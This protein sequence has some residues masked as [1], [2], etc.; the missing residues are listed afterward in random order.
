MAKFVLV[1]G[2]WHGAWCWYKVVSRLQAAGHEA[3]AVDLPGMG[4]DVTPLS[5][6]TLDLWNDALVAVL[7][8]QSEPVVL[9]GHSR[10][11]LN[12][13]LAAATA[14]ERIKRLVYLCAFVPESGRSLFEQAGENTGSELS[15]ALV[16]SADGLS[17]VVA[18]SRL[19][20]IFYADCSEDDLTLARLSLKPEPLAP[21]NTPFEGSAENLAGI[22]KVYVECL[23][24]QAITIE[25]Q[26]RMAS[27]CD[28]V[29]T[30]DT[31]H[32]PFFS[33]PDALV[34]VLVGSAGN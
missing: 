9:V 30:M 5:E 24:D 8:D 26:R 11:G 14:P 20:D 15:T 31:S 3:V 22:D 4:A 12:I 21:L 7:R 33:A 32:S 13:S 28:S 29:V 6:V 10:G 23:Q 18:E 2:S 1:H 25:T 34:E 16:P 27:R 17:T 19:Q